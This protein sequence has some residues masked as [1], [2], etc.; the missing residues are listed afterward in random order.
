MHMVEFILDKFPPQSGMILTL[1][2]TI[3][4]LLVSWYQAG[5]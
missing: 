2:L 4:L 3:I 1:Y 5:F